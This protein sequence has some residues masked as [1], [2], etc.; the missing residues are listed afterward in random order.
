MKNKIIAVVIT[1]IYILSLQSNLIMVSADSGVKNTDKANILKELGLF[2]GTDKGY[3]LER[4]PTRAES[5]VMLV[6]MLGKEKA[7]VEKNYPTPFTDV[8]VWASPFVGYL[9]SSKSV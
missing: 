7:A 1:L 9:N 6:R 4:K 3:E 5:A 2:I 8:P